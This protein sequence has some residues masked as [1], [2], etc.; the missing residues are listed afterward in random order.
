MSSCWNPSAT[1]S[2][3]AIDAAAIF[4]CATVADG[5]Q[6]DDMFRVTAKLGD[7]SRGVGMLDACGLLLCGGEVFHHEIAPRSNYNEGS[8][9]FWQPIY[10]GVQFQPLR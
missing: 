7:R 10:L 5:F 2:A 3:T 6:H 4:G 1:A 8:L 9:A